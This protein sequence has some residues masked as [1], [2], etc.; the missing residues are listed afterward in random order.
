MEFETR[1]P[2]VDFS[3]GGVSGGHVL[4]F[5]ADSATLNDALLL[6]MLAAFNLIDQGLPCVAIQ[7]DEPHFLAARKFK[8]MFLPDKYH[9]LMKAIDEG[10]FTYLDLVSGRVPS[11]ENFE[12]LVG[13]VPVRNDIDRIL[14]EANHAMEKMR[15]MFPGSPV[16]LLYHN[17]S[18][19][20]VDFDSKAAL[21]MFKKLI[22]SI[23]QNG[24]I[25]IGVVNRD[26]H[27]LEITN[28]LKHFSNY[29]MEFGLDFKEDSPHPYL[30]VSKTPMAGFARKLLHKKVAYYISGN[31][32]ETF[33][34]AS[35]YLD[36]LEDGQVFYQ[37]GEISV[38]GTKHL[39][40]PTQLLANLLLNFEKSIDYDTYRK[41]VMEL[42]KDFGAKN[43]RIVESEFN[44]KEDRLLHSTLMYVGARGYGRVLNIEGSLE[45]GS[46]KIR[47]HSSLAEL[48][49]KSN[50]PVD[51]LIEGGLLGAV[52]EITGKI[53]TSKEVRCIA[54]GD[55]YCE[56]EL[57]QT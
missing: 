45:S 29:A 37:K 18:S 1:I 49:G 44:F 8:H 56:F 23:K 26:I 21:N 5:I 14:Y 6:S 57:T 12:G 36:E 16:I 46:L 39:V 27:E 25:L 54:M 28:T 22:T 52:Q 40:F 55:D 34:P 3:L 47:V 13:I 4:L 31:K 43:V 15:V 35:F 33:S 53:W 38:L 24:D 9:A 10:R 20:M 41:I 2:V 48:W 7:T 17:I 11:G 30:Q 32:F 51:I 19:T 50:K 42:G